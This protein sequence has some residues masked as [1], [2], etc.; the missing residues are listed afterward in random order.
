MKMLCEASCCRENHNNRRLRPRQVVLGLRLCAVC[1][2]RLAHDLAGLPELYDASEAALTHPRHRAVERI[3]GGRPDGICLNDAVVK[4]RSDMLRILAS[5]A[6]MVVDERGVTGPDQREIRHLAVFLTSHVDWLAAQT[7]AA[8][9]ADEIA[10]LAKSARESINPN[11]MTRMELG[12]CAQS[13]CGQ[14]VH[15][16]VRAEDELLP[17]QVS[18]QAGHVWPPHQWLLLGRRIEQAKRR[19]QAGAEPAEDA[20]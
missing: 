20:T 19:H 12:P 18:C 9:L 1:R 15:A 14:T 7:T 6:G 13:G 2:D 5:W 8:A 16:V 11:T 10:G 3:R 4:A 17:T